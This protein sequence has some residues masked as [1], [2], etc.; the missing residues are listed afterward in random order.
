VNTQPHRFQHWALPR[1]RISYIVDWNTV[2]MEQLAENLRP[3][4]IIGVEGPPRRSIMP[5]ELDIPHTRR[6]VSHQPTRSVRNRKSNAHLA[7]GRGCRNHRARAT[8]VRLQ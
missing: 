2:D 7:K 1:T 4:H 3:G 8:Q 6:F 5:V